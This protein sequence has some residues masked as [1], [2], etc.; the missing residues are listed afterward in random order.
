M[1]SNYGYISLNERVHSCCNMRAC[2]AGLKQERQLW[3]QSGRVLFFL[4]CSSNISL[5][6][7]ILQ[8]NSFSSYFTSSQNNSLCTFCQTET[9]N[10]TNT[11]RNTVYCLTSDMTRVITMRKKINIETNRKTDQIKLLSKIQHIIQIF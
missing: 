3:V 7:F 4:L 5:F 1:F 10:H 9:I 6:S 2:T 11:S 8:K